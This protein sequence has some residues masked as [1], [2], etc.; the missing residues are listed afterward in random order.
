MFNGFKTFATK[1]RLEELER[2][3]EYN[4]RKTL[5]ETVY[6]VITAYFNI[7]KLK[8]QLKATIEQIQLYQ[9]RLPVGRHE[10]LILAVV[11]SLK[12]CR[13]GVDLNEQKANQ[14]TIQNQINI[15]KSNLV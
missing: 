6:N 15:A 4:F 10:I 3:G 1:R 14:L 12:C 5:N 7:V 11:Q 8:E 9:D 2:I 13:P